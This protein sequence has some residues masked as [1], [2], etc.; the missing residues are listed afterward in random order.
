MRKE[1]AVI[2]PIVQD[3]AIPDPATT[4][5]EVF[6]TELTPVSFLR[7]SAAVFPDK[8]A[9]VHGNRGTSYSYRQLAER[10]DRFA[11]ALRAAGL[12]RGDRVAFLSPNIPAVLEAHFAV[13]AAG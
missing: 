1:T 2:A 6:R 3:T 8:T 7:R 12:R 4:R 11:S 9:V 5:Q 13:P 10:V